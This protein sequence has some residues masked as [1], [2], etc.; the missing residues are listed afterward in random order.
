MRP[1]VEVRLGKGRFRETL[2]LSKVSLLRAGARYGL[3]FEVIAGYPDNIFRAIRGGKGFIFQHWPGYRTRRR[4]PDFECL[5]D[6]ERQKGLLRE[7]GFRVPRQLQVVTSISEIDWS[8]LSYPLVVKPCVGRMS[9]NVVVNIRSGEEVRDAVGAVSQVVRD[10]FWKNM[11]AVNTTGSCAWEG[12]TW[13]A[14]GGGRQ[15]CWGTGNIESVN[16]WRCVVRSP[17]EDRA[18]TCFR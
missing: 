8:C 1:N 17:A 13:D 2:D 15:V 9:I 18:A 14:F 3:G 10:A 12:G 4:E 11:C 5:I 16:F 6:K 7:C